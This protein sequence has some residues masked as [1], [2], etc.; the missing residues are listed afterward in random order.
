VA[1]PE[2]RD[3]QRRDRPARDEDDVARQAQP[4]DQRVGV[5]GQ[6]LE[7]ARLDFVAK[8]P[9]AAGCLIDVGSVAGAG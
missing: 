7:L 3:V 8:D 2:V 5:A 6:E 9:Y 1:N 4:L